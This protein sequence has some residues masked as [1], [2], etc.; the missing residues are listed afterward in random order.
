VKKEIFLTVVERVSNRCGHNANG[1]IQFKSDQLITNIMRVAIRSNDPKL[2]AKNAPDNDSSKMLLSVQLLSKRQY[3]ST[4]PLPKN[5]PPSTPIREH[6]PPPNPPLSNLNHSLPLRS[7]F[8][9]FISTTE[10]MFTLPRQPNNLPTRTLNRQLR[11]FEP[12]RIRRGT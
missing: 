8:R 2:Q 7:L 5:T 10:H 9:C 3:S 11:R 1:S 6:Q 4:L 12:P